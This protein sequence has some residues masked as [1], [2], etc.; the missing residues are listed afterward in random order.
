[1]T[2]AHDKPCRS[3]WRG[4]ARATHAPRSPRFRAV[5]AQACRVAP[6]VLSGVVLPVLL[7]VA[8]VAQA[9]ADGATLWANLKE[10]F[11]GP[12]GL[13]LGAILLGIGIGGF[14]RYGFGWLAVVCGLCVVLFLVPAL[15]LLFQTYGKSMATG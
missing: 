10:L 9:A 7:A 3:G 1:M 6:L 15:V 8:P 13:V 5:R 11:F 4:I 2:E 12:W 14:F